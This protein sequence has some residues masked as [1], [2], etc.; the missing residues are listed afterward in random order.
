LTAIPENGIA[1]TTDNVVYRGP[2]TVGNGNQALSVV[3]DTTGALSI[4]EGNSCTTCGTTKYDETAAGSTWALGAN[5]FS[6]T[7]KLLDQSKTITASGQE[8]TDKLC[9]GTTCLA[10]AKIGLANTVVNADTNTDGWIGLA[11]GKG[12]NDA[13]VQPPAGDFIIN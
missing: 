13:G 3:F 4:I 8:G 1:I 2:I 7:W 9:I 6:R 10:T 11:L 5:P 12:N